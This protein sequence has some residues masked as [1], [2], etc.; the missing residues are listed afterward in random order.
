MIIVRDFRESVY[1]EFD[2]MHKANRGDLTHVDAL[3]HESDAKFSGTNTSF[4][5]YLMNEYLLSLL[6]E[7]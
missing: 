2:K 3:F 7:N 6:S 1:V 5:A 4:S